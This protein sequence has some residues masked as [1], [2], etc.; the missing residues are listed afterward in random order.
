[1][2]KTID[3]LVEDME[4]VILGNDGWE[5]TLG[6]VMADTI[7]Q[8]ASDRFSKPQEPRGYLSMAH[9]VIVNSGTR[10]TRLT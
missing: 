4:S 10:S 3:T 7:A 6:Q 5:H 8:Q 1:M 2:T 9:H